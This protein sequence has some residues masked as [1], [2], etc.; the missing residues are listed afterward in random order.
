MKSFDTSWTGDCNTDRRQRASI[1]N[2][3]DWKYVSSSVPQGSIIGP[4]PFLIYINDTGSEPSPDTL[5]PLYAMTQNAAELYEVNKTETY[6]NKTY[7]Q[8]YINGVRPGV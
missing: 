6:C 2:I 1:A 3:S 7:P 5:L 8:A 4:N